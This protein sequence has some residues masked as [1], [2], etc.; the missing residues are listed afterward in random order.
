MAPTVLLFH[1]CGGIRP[2][3]A[4]Y[5]EAA[6]R[7]GVRAVVVDSYA[8]RGWSRAFAMTAVCTGAMFWGRERAGDVLAAAWGAVQDLGADP[9]RLVLAGFSHGA[10]SIMDLMTMPLQRT[11]EAGL[12]DPSPQS[13]EGVRGLFLGYAYGGVRTHLR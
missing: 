13:L 1:G 8:P 9:N 10:W 7:L 5:A 11:G 2:Q 4:H 12:L 3:M 6:V